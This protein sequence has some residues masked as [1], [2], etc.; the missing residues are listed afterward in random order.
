MRCLELLKKQVREK[1]VRWEH[2]S[3]K[4]WKGAR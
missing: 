4:V 3:G 2:R 1:Q